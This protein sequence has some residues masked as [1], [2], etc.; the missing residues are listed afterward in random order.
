MAE[1]P[2]STIHEKSMPSVKRHREIGVPAGGEVEFFYKNDK[3]AALTAGAR[4]SPW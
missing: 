1:V 3:A 4:F 2:L